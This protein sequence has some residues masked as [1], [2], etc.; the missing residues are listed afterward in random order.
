M[1]SEAWWSVVHRV[2]ESQTWL[3]Q[4]NIYKCM[5]Y[6]SNWIIRS[7]TEVPRAASF[8][9]PGAYS[10]RAGDNW[11]KG[12]SVTLAAW[13]F[14]KASLVWLLDFSRTPGF[15]QGFPG[16]SYGKESACNSGD[17]VAKI[18]CRRAWLLL[19]V[20]LLGEFHGQ[21]SLVG[22]S[23]GGCKELDITEPQT[24]LL[25]GFYS[26]LSDAAELAGHFLG[27]P[28][29]LLS[30]QERTSSGNRVTLKQLSRKLPW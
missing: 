13:A 26:G 17:W 11:N 8:H 19:P 1:D 20:F 27:R 9:I 24:L 10:I 2:T 18:P 5:Y 7:S 3:K 28:W 6:F 25:S 12:A 4:L 30:P 16:G 15:T 22:Y 14:A 29:M 21:R 23:Q